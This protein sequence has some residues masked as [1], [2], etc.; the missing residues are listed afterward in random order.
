MNDQTNILIFIIAASIAVFLILRELMCWYYKINER[1]KLQ[2]ETNRL[3][4]ELIKQNS[5]EPKSAESKVEIVDLK[6]LNMA[7]DKGEIS[8]EEYLRLLKTHSK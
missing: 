5:G 8:Q 2:Q 1:V 6:T 4:A 7:R 3:L